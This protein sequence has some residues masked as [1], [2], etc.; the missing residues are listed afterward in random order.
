MQASVY[1]IMTVLLIYDSC[2]Y[3]MFLVSLNIYVGY[4]LNTRGM[5]ECTQQDFSF[6]N[7]KLE[8]FTK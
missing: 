7:K 2:M 1:I 8:S 5:K 6:N 4:H 3:G